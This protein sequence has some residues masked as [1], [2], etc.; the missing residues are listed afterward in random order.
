MKQEE[1]FLKRIISIKS[2]LILIITGC[3]QVSN[4]Y[5]NIRIGACFFIW[6]NLING[7]FLHKTYYFR[8]EAFLGQILL[9]IRFMIHNCNQNND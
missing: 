9:Y 2:S 4:S 7:Q 1:F 8:H 6:S 5:R 3:G